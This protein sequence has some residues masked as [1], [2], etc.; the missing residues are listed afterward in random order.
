MNGSN[1]A[2]QQPNYLFQRSN[3]ADIGPATAR[4]ILKNNRSVMYRTSVR[5]LTPDEIQSP[6]ENKEREEFEI[7]IEK[8]C[9]ASMD[10][11]DFKDDPEYA[12][13]VTPIYDFYEDD[14]VSSSNMPDIDDM[15]TH[16]TNILEAM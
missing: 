13:F 1:S 10:K 3:W 14:E 6:T 5:S 9:G 2:I 12:D 11:N 7:V 8:K 4:K 16:I 15:L